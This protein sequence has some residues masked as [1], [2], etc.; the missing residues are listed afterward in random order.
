LTG[1]Q[2]LRRN[3]K[4]ESMDFRM[5]FTKSSASSLK[6]KVNSVGDRLNDKGSNRKSEEAVLLRIVLA[7][8]SQSSSRNW[9]SIPSH[10]VRPRPTE[11]G[12][13]SATS[14]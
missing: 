8:T 7:I 13:H 9:V 2:A 10:V 14:L 11:Y 12:P 6:K 3:E 4:R 1:D 5:N